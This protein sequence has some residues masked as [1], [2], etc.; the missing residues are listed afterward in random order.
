MSPED[1]GKR[2]VGQYYL[3]E[4]IAQG[5]MAEIYKGLSYDLHGLKKTVVIKKILPHIAASKEFIDSLIDE[6]KIAVT[7]SHGNIAQTYDLG[8]V[9]DDYFMVMEYVEGKSL[10]LIH[11]RCL[12]A[13]KLIPIPYLC[14]F[15][16]EVLSGLDYMHRRTDEKGRPLHIIH[17]DIS[18]QNLIITYSGTL[19]IIDFGIAKA[20]IKIGSTDS[21]VLKGKFSYMSPEQARGDPID[22]RSDI[23][24]LGVIFHEMLTGKRLFKTDDT[25]ET[26]R[27][28]RRA[29]VEPPSA[30]RGDL[31]DEID[32]IVMKAL[33]KDRRHRHA[34]AS[35]MRDDLLKFLSSSYP[36]FQSSEA[37]DFVR[38][39]FKDELSKVSEEEEMK[40]PHLI[41]DST[42]SAL[43]DESQF[44]D[45]GHIRTPIDMKDY[46]LEEEDVPETAAEEPSLK[47]FPELAVVEELSLEKAPKIQWSALFLKRKV[48]IF[49]ASLGI[50]FLLISIVSSFNLWK[51]APAGG[52]I[53]K[54]EI[55]V[56][57]DPPDSRISIGGKL[58]GSGSPITINDIK[59]G[60]ENE[61]TVEREGYVPQ[62][63]KI[64]LK[65]G[66]FKSIDIKLTKATSTK[67]T[68]I[69]SSTP[70][71][72]T[73]FLDDVETQHRTPATLN[74][75]DVDKRHVL[76]LF[77]QG[78]R[79]WSRDFQAHTGETQNFD[80]Q[81]ARNFGSL[82]IDS[83]PNGAL[84]MLDGTPAGQ[85][86]FIRDNIEPQTVYRVE[87]WL[88]GY[89]PH[90]DEIQIEA[91]KKRELH[92]TLKKAPLI[93]QQMQQPAP[94][95]APA[96]PMGPAPIEETPEPPAGAPSGEPKL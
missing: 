35:D 3:M 13:G 47:P 91:G 14:Y 78:Y 12:A 28:V 45:T 46:L 68:V 73:I 1:K 15:I 53:A 62:T 82:T 26:L 48:P 66:E 2:S 5:G 27:N 65:E 76:G 6:A 22:H 69:V 83:S 9:G 34:F 24:S 21:G 94:S 29:K 20:A 89:E 79:Y 36:E 41:I 33:S 16:S 59:S 93:P 64:K 58:I 71:G 57:T 43:T 61:I 19:K 87:V 49:F 50:I 32:R 17:R 40:T 84:V 42:S 81:L 18:P 60:E 31:P 80:V 44:E 72:A 63:Q 67:C 8:K 95:P 75:I 88:E 10:S 92:V 96:Q 11:K 30:F 90:T 86:P 38:D 23:F 25:R 70:P 4:K 54:S 52:D 74:N 77:L 39:L 37:G 85:T 51:R 55:L 7:L 56:T